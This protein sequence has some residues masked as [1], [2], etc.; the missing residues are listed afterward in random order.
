MALLLALMSP[1]FLQQVKVPML[2]A[3]SLSSGI[4][5]NI[6]LY[7]PYS[8]SPFIVL[9]SYFFETDNPMSWGFLLSD[10][11]CKTS[12]QQTYSNRGFHNH[13]PFYSS[14][15]N[16]HWSLIVISQRRGHTCQKLLPCHVLLHVS[17][18][19]IF[20]RSLLRGQ[21]HHPYFA[22]LAGSI[23]RDDPPAERVPRVW[24]KAPSHY[25]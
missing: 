9:P 17:R 4:A 6:R 20:V 21:V 15:N 14:L 11:R 2:D 22:P 24:L 16:P 3:P 10:M 23:F 7:A 5:T 13:E 19:V 25:T 8:L 1:G 12:G 18:P